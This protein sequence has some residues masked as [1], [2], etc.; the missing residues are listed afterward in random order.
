M[1][2]NGCPAEGL[3]C[4]S[5][6]TAFGLAFLGASQPRA[7][8]DIDTEAFPNGIE[9]EKEYEISGTAE[10]M[11]GMFRFMEP[12][13]GATAYVTADGPFCERFTAISGGTALMARAS[14]G[15]VGRIHSMNLSEVEG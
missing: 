7:Q 10:G 4:I 14:T 2:K 11:G 1:L 6:T 13:G 12:G 3:T 9:A 15:T 5:G 8:F